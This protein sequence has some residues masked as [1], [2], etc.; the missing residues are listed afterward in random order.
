MCGGASRPARQ[1]DHREGRGAD[2]ELAIQAIAV[3]RPRKVHSG[4]ADPAGADVIARNASF[5]I[6]A[7]PVA[8]AAAHVLTPDP[9]MG[10]EDRLTRIGASNIR[11]HVYSLLDRP[12]LLRGCRFVVVCRETVLIEVSRASKR[13]NGT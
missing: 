11:I 10:I 1:L 12:Y 7:A 5:R 13:E 4:L 6:N 9:R 8:D 3:A 2:F